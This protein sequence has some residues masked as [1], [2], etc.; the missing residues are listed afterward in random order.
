MTE[1]IL[2]LL[3][4]ENGTIRAAEHSQPKSETLN[5]AIK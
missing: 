4:D 5:K 3:P 1:L 2:D